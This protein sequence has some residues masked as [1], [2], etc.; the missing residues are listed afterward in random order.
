[1][2]FLS[3]PPF[4]SSPP[5]YITASCYDVYFFLGEFT[6]EKFNINFSLSHSFSNLTLKNGK[7]RTH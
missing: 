1:M 2:Y 5:V 7:E 6:L 3:S 4:S